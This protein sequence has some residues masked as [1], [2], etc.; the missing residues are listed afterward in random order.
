MPIE[1]LVD[2][3]RRLRRPDTDPLED[4]WPAL[5]R[6]DQRVVARY[7]DLVLGSVYQPILASD[8]QQIVGYEA[9]LR[10]VDPAGA[11]V[12]PEAV[13]RLPRSGEEAT[14][15]DRLC[16]VLH[17]LNLVRQPGQ[18]LAGYLFLNVTP[19]HLLQLAGE[20]GRAFE[21]VIRF[22]GISPDKVVLEVLES[23]ID[24]LQT[25]KGA[26]AN[27]RARGYRI[28]IDDFGRNHSNFDRLWLLEPD[29]V[30]FDRS[31]LLQAERDGRIRRVL[32]LLVEIVHELDAKAL[33]EGIENPAQ[34]QIA[35]D[36]GV[37]WIQG[38]HLGRP[39]AEPVRV[40]A[41]EEAR[42]PGALAL[43]H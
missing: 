30:K 12:A 20:H 19:R 23:D 39:L 15:L 37:D 6:Q 18:G 43:P 26:L 35:R 10:A 14:Y 27:Y 1:L 8:G 41:K 24:D 2:Y 16:R 9:L 3:F 7:H 36:A 34:L 22:F 25:L 4:Y 33:L 28:A 38:Y 29:I 13:F 31:L 40:A 17:V 42:W 5:D 21:A 32:P 11:P